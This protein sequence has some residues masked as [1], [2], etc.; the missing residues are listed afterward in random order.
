LNNTSEISW[1]SWPHYGNEEKV[2]VERV[3]ESNQLFAADR[4]RE[5][6]QNFLEYTGTSFAKGVGNAT[7]GLHLSLAALDIGEGDEVIVTPYTFI[8]SASSILMQNAVPIFC[9]CDAQTRAL[10]AEKIESHI[11]SRTRAIIVVHMFGYPADMDPIL[12]LARNHGLAVIE[13][14]SHAYGAEYKGRRCGSIG[15]L[16]VFS[17]HQRKSLSAGDGGIVVTND[18]EINERIY[19]LRSFGHKQLSYNY[20]MTEFAG[21]LGLVQLGKLDLHNNIRQRNAE[22]IAELLEK[23]DGLDVIRPL[24]CATSVFY[25]V[26]LHFHPEKFNCDLLEFS[27]VVAQSGVPLEP[28]WKLIH[29]HPH[30]NPEEAPARGLPWESQS[31]DGVMK[32]KKYESLSFPVIENLCA[33]HL[34]ELCVHPPVSEKEITFATQIIEETVDKF[35][36]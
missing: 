35:S 14:A 2:A 33:N 13:D 10:S 21:A 11:S 18:P 36:R 19:R 27:S 3:I 24:A 6:E 20:R 28:T 15:D 9:D 16:G 31:Y 1:P 30:F 26:L 25:R 4:V 32:G 8:A 29:L 23:V 5:F 7:Q 12:E 17:M 22:L 34:L